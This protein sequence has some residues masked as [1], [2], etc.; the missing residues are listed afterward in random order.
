MHERLSFL[1]FLLPSKRRK[2]YMWRDMSGTVRP[3]VVISNDLTAL[4]AIV[5]AAVEVETAVGIPTR[6][7]LAK[8][9]TGV[10]KRVACVHCCCFDG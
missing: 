4:A 8:E 6:A 3:V 2:T 10:V 1:S 5:L 9:T 7:S